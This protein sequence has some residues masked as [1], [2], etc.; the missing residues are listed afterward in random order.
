M[1][2][3]MPGGRN[4]GAVRVGQTVRRR[5]GTQTPAVH[6]LLRHLEAVGFAGAPRAI[7]IDDQGREVLTYLDGCTVGNSRPWPA[8]AHSE[9]TLV[10]VGRWLRDFHAASRSFVPPPGAHWFGGRDELGPGEL[11]GHHDAAPYNA[12]WRPT[13]SESDPG[14]GELVG[15]IDWDL[16]HPAEPVRDLAFALLTWVPLTARDVAAA[17][18]FPPDVDRAGRLRLVLEAYEW[19]GTLGEVL[20][21][22]RLRAV[23]HATGLR[24]AAAAGYGPAAALVAEGVAEDFDR[25]AAELDAS[26]GDLLHEGDA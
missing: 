17:D 11:V 20:A 14:L 16:A 8:W 7:G 1:E 10:A 23:E 6:A 25:A 12:V 9:V 13:P 3:Q 24:R 18:G 4:D 19:T 21:A 22:V 26:M 15:F 2:Q 5:A